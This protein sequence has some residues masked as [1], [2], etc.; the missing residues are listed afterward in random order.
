MLRRPPPRRG[1]PRPCRPAPERTSQMCSR[2]SSSMPSVTS[3]FA[4]SRGR[5]RLRARNA[6]RDP[7][8]GKGRRGLA[9]V[10]PGPPRNLPAMHE[11][12]LGRNGLAV[13]AIGLGCM[14]MSDFYG[15]RDDAESVA[16]IH[17]ALELG[18]DFFDTADMYGPFTNERLLGRAL[19]DRRDRAVIATKFGNER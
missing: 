11:R 17:R 3:R 12:T 4:V 9:S 15:P 6:E 2:D 10:P 18:I 13:S 19:A 8:V 1:T 16:T 5:R 7:P 14:G